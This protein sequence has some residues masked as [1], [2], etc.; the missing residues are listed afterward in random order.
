MSIFPDRELLDDLPPPEQVRNW[1]VTREN[2]LAR[3]ALRGAIWGGIIGA[4]VWLVAQV[5]LYPFS[6]KGIFNGRVNFESI[7][8]VIVAIVI[9]ALNFRS[10]WQKNEKT[11]LAVIE[12]EKKQTHLPSEPS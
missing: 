11:Y 1:A 5:I 12:K 3:Y 8:V 6:E 7:G 4:S 9:G 2:G 10:N